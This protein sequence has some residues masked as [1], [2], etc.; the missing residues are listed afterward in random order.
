[1]TSPNAFD[2]FSN[3]AAAVEPGSHTI[4]AVRSG[5]N[6][7]GP[8]IN[9]IASFLTAGGREDTF[10]IDQL[11]AAIAFR[12]KRKEDASEY[13]AAARDLQMA[14]GFLPEH[15]EPQPAVA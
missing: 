14:L 1:M 7:D 9:Y 12:Q 15:Q 8:V 6:P 2:S 11:D 10:T 5:N 3:A 4:V 13:E